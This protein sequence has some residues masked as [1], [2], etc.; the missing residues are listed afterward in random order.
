MRLTVYT[1]YALRLL[2]YLAVQRDGLATVA[3]IA[4]SYGISRNHLTKVVHQLGLTGYIETV[5][6][7]GGGMRLGRPAAEIVLGEVVRLTETDMV[8]VPCFDPLNTECPLRGACVLRNALKH[9]QSAFI[10][11]LDGYT[12]ADLAAGPVA[13]RR[14][15]G[16]PASAAGPPN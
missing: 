11:V 13:M 6:G 2:M 3:D 16:I 1:D 4:T 14:M 7:R 10:D 15:L 9:A 12:L 5:R 8:L